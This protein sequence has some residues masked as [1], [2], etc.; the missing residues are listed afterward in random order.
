MAY[1][2]PLDP[3]KNRDCMLQSRFIVSISLPVPNQSRNLI[4]FSRFYCPSPLVNYFGSLSLEYSFLNSH[5]LYAFFGNQAFL[6]LLRLRS[7]PACSPW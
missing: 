6:V 7:W 2:D 1:D 3:I 4:K 5:S